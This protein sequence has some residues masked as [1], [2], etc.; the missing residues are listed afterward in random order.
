MKI[1]I[2]D[3]DKDEHEVT[4][5]EGMTIKDAIEDV[6]NDHNFAVCGGACCCATC[7]VYVETGVYDS[8]SDK[9]DKV[10]NEQG[11]DTQTNS[12]LSCMLKLYAVNDG[13]KF[14]IPSS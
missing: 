14:I 9:E 13:D 3:Q 12:R 6:V 5:T 7:H 4:F 8:K 10:L 2:I 11:E 1:Y